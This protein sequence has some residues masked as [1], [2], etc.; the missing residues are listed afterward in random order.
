ML[1]STQYDSYSVKT[2]AVP[3]RR[4]SEGHSRRG[5]RAYG[6]IQIPRLPQSDSGES[7]H[8]AF[9]NE[10]IH[11][12]ILARLDELDKCG[13]LELD[14]IELEDCCCEDL[15]QKLVEMQ[16]MLDQLTQQHQQQQ[17]M[18]YQEM[19]R[20]SLVTG[21]HYQQLLRHMTA[22]FMPLQAGLRALSVD[23]PLQHQDS[24]PTMNRSMIRR[25]TASGRHPWQRYSM[26]A[27]LAFSTVQLLG[28]A[29]F[30]FI[31]VCFT[32]GVLGTESLAPLLVGVGWPVFRALAVVTLVGFAIASLVE[33][34]GN[35]R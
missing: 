33:S 27:R 8:R 34:M 16:A 28:F 6:P 4:Q 14:P 32:V 13:E 23:V 35:R 31:L 1:H 5:T 26:T 2:R 21:S 17:Q 22:N 20:L 12:A 24:G 9:H 7:V 25:T 10:S 3:P 29:T 30:A 19:Q 15:Q 18:L 11:R